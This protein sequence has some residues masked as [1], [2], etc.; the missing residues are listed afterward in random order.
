MS[1]APTVIRTS[2][3]TARV[4]VRLPVI[5]TVILAAVTTLNSKPEICI[6]LDGLLA[7]QKAGRNGPIGEA[8]PGASAF[9]RRL[10]KLYRVII[11]THRCHWELNLDRPTEEQLDRACKP[12]I[13]WCEKN[14]IWYDGV[15]IGQGKPDCELFI[16]PRELQTPLNPVPDDFIEIENAIRERIK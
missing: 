13:S 5:A 3:K 8:R 15:Y 6:A 4:P 16:G 12:V 2:G 1:I 14:N 9:T 10:G 7:T 11:Y